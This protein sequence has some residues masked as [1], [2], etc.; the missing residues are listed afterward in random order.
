V[1]I[2]CCSIQEDQA[3]LHLLKK[4]L[5][6]LQREGLITIQ[7]ALD[8]RPGDAYEHSIQQYLNTAHLILI[9]VSP[10]L[11]ASDYYYDVEMKRALKR[12]TRG[13]ARVIPLLLSPTLLERTPLAQLQPLPTN[14]KPIK[15]WDSQDEAFVHIAE[16][17]K[18]EAQKLQA[19]QKDQPATRLEV[20]K[21]IPAPQNKKGEKVAQNAKGNIPAVTTPGPPR[22]NVSVPVATSPVQPKKPHQPPV[23]SDA[24]G[25]PAQSGLRMSV[26]QTSKSVFTA[27]VQGVITGG[28][29]HT[30][31]IHGPILPVEDPLA[32]ALE[33]TERGYEALKR[34]D[35]LSAK[36]CLEV[37][38]RALPEHKLPSEAAQVKY[39]LALVLLNGQRPF[40]V[41]T[42]TMQQ[43]E[44]I[45]MS[46]IHL[47]PLHSYYYTLALMKRDFAR[48]GLPHYKQHAQNL[49]Q[50]SQR[51]NKTPID[52]KNLQILR[53][54]QPRLM[55]DAQNW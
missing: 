46:A 30:I 36:Q 31:N 7:S 12:Q 24:S 26:Q 29:N 9:L 32:K 55:S 15:Q 2:Y 42:A 1:K 33:E 18:Q 19:Q 10:E 49:R 35:Y 34:K 44:Q 52:N 47:R 20:A 8:V 54:C 43:I 23:R 16:Q 22:K 27:P 14:K 39:A 25:R 6:P 13:E 41:Q 28:N 50:K 37:A 48:N 21:G 45:L 3:F 40:D 51:I 11:L 5:T 38:N 4:Y 17:I 53:I